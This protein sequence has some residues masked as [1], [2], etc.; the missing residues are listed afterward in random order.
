MRNVVAHL[1]QAY[2]EELSRVYDTTVAY[3]E[4]WQQAEKWDIFVPMRVAMI[5]PYI[6]E[7]HCA[8]P[9]QKHSSVGWVAMWD[10]ICASVAFKRGKQGGA[11]E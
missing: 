7:R 2:Y 11:L 8:V 10:E 1:L 3:L 5:L 9:L 6:H 4:E